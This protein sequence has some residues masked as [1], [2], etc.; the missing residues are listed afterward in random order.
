LYYYV[1]GLQFFGS[2]TVQNKNNNNR[3]RVGF[4]AS[5]TLF[6]FVFERSDNVLSAMVR[7]DGENIVFNGSYMEMYIP[8]FYFENNKLAEDFG[9]SLR[10]FG[11]FN[12]RTF[13]DKNRPMKL[14]TFNIPTMIYVH[15]SEIEKRAIQLIP[16]DDNEVE[17][18]RVAK[19]YKGNVVMQNSV[20]QDAS[21]VELFLGILTAGK[22]PKTI[23][24]SQVLQVWQKNLELN[25]VKLGVTSTILEII[26]SEVY[27]NNKKPEENFAKVIGK[28]PK[29][30]EYA[31]RTANIRE[32]CARNSTF[33]ALTFE[34]M[35]Q[36]ITSS[37][38]IN[39]YNKQESNSPIEKIIKM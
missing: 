24:Y 12:V 29:T 20:P 2:I 10:V 39:K 13:D 19:F 18:Y 14:E 5:L 11:L 36:M 37:L 31:Y 8:E 7:D 30:S 15:P 23:P 16:G 26:I 1:S 35:D 38:N 33:A 21:N 27:R 4:H 6:Y 34:D 25:G 22:V 32:I 3:V 28:D 9:N 17:P